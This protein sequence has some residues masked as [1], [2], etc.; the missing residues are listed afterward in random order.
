M[1]IL[2]IF[3]DGLGVSKF[4]TATNPC[5]NNSLKLFNNFSNRDRETELPF[6]GL[7]KP[8]DA[9]LSLAG[10]PQ[11][12]TGQTA[13]LTGVNAAQLL[14]RHLS[15]YPNQKLRELLEKES[16]LKIFSQQKK[17]AA[18]INAYRPIF[19]KF[20]PE[21]LIK[22]L[23]VTSIANWKAGL[24]FYSFK[25]LKE[26]QSIYHDFTNVEL[27]NKGF[28]VP[29]FSAEKAGTILAKTAN[30]LDFCLYE[31]FKTDKAGH[32]QN[33][34][35]AINL[36]QQL[37]LFILTVLKN[38]DLKTTLILVASDHGNIEDLSI[39]THTRNLVPLIV[40]GKNSE[41]FLEQVE[42]IQDIAGALLKLVFGY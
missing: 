16:L 41:R 12:A 37:E 13:L 24:K 22:Y 26:E 7:F 19:F 6:S 32:A 21:A 28:E 36:L 14:G 20:G 39:K 23:S 27:I 5:S 4:N 3:I 2:F 9:C 35:S 18:F 8:I 31:Y 25:D 40:W 33:M 29:I 10:L 11:S 15:G 30:S 17:K 38:T 42:A 34:N 1:K